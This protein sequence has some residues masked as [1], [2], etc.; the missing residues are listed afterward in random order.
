MPVRVLVCVRVSSL[1]CKDPHVQ[2]QVSK[3]LVEIIAQQASCGHTNVYVHVCK[4][5]IYTCLHTEY[6]VC[7]SIFTSIYIHIHNHTYV[8]I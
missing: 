2:E 7:M 8:I 3:P 6:V 4:C 1:A 5:N